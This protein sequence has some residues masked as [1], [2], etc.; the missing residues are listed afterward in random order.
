[1]SG[2]QAPER[3]VRDAEGLNT[4]C[5]PIPAEDFVTPTERFFTRS[6]APFP[7]VDPAAWRLE[8]SGMIERPRVFS[9]GELLGTFPRREVTA[10]LVCAGLRRDEYL[11]FGPLPGELPWGSDPVSTGR[12]AGVAMADLLRA[13]GVSSEACHVQMVG[14]DDVER[15]GHR[16][17]FGGSID[18]AKAMR[19][20]VLLATELNGAPLPQAHGFPL[21]A[22]VP[23]WIGARSVKWLGRIQV[24]TEPSPNYFQTRAYRMARE[25][26]HADPR[27]VARGTALTEV[28]LNT[29]I[30]APAAGAVLPA[31]RHLVRGW[32]MGAGGAA[33]ARVELSLDGG[34]SWHPARVA[35]S[36]ERWAWSFWE[37]EVTLEPGAHTI[38][39]RAVSADGET[40]PTSAQETWNVKG[41]GNNAWYRVTL[42]AE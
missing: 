14:L 12:W 20:E 9:L 34:R 26:N 25:V 38:M 37:L 5:W 1:M 32:S 16:F 6:H 39:A 21:R 27:D 13:V 23:G 10:T 41:Y 40:Q 2:G 4:A 8:V 35:R 42:R 19:R 22:V 3:R 28:P 33:L 36:G 15:H 31:G 17:G 11:A 18:L 29:V 24:S 7:R 30:L